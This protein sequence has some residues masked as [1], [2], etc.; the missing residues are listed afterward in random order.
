M[1]KNRP[2]KG[3]VLLM[4][5]TRKGAFIYWSNQ[6]RQEWQ[7][8][9]HHEGWMTHHMAIDPSDQSIYAATN[10]EVF[11]G[12]VQRSPDFG[13]S[14]EKQNEKL[15]YDP[16][17]AHRVRKIWHVLPTKEALY[18]GVE[19]AGLFQ[20]SDQARNWTEI[21]GL[22]RHQHS[23][24]WEPGAGGLILHTIIVDPSDSN[25]IYVAISTGGVY[26]TDDGGQTWEPKNQGVRADFLPDKFPEYGQCVHTLAMHPSQPDTLY[27]QNHC[28]VYRSDDRGDSWEDISNGLPSRFGFPFVIHAHD[29]DTVYVVPLDSDGN[30]VIPEGRMTVWKSTDR[31]SSW[32]PKTNGLPDGA[33]LTVLR[34]AM[35]V[36]ACDSC[37][38]Y[39]GTQTG[40]V[41]FSRDEGESWEVL[42]NFLPP[43]YSLSTG[44]I[45]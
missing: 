26:R 19:R 2:S 6:E 38:I 8:S 32:E 43:V 44:M 37:G 17:H 13:G 20:S 12:V 45:A 42:A 33:Y 16:D 41:F 18:A 11:G 28:G 31:G 3:D 21:E 34:E 5:G 24:H 1:P 15:D 29:P 39:V 35:A 25:R 27:Q 10:G 23:E 4:V 30:R 36:D 40:E 9:F 7:R 22:N 14:W